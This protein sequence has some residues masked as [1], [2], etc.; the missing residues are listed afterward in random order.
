MRFYPTKIHLT[1]LCLVLFSITLNLGCSKDTDVL[2]DTVAA[3][4]DIS[5]IEEISTTTSEESELEV[6]T[7][8]EELSV[9]ELFESRSVSFSPT[10]DAH[11][12]LGKGY[13]QNIIRLEQNYR[14]SFLMFDLSPIEALGGTITGAILQFTIDSDDGN[15]S[16]S[17]Y[18]GTTNI[19]SEDNLDESTAP[20]MGVELGAIIKEYTIGTTEQIE[21]NSSDISP[22]ISTLILDHEDGNDLAFASKEHISKIGPKLVI[23]YN[24]PAGSEEIFIEE[25][26]EN[27]TEE[28]DTNEEPMAV[29]DASPTSGGAPLEV[30]FTS[31]S[32][33][34]D[35]EVSSYAWDFKDGSTSTE[36]NPVHTFTEVGSYIVELT[37]KDNEG[38]T[39]VDTV[40]ITVG[41]DENLAPKA[42]AS[43]N[44]QTG[45]AP[46]EITFK[47]SDST[48]DYN[49]TSYEWDFKDGSTAAQANPKHTFTTPGVYNVTLTVTDE[50]GLT[51]EG[52]ITITVSENTNEAP[53][54][55]ASVTPA[56]GEAPLQVRF[57]GSNS[58]DDKS[59]TNYAWALNPGGANAAD[60]N[61][62]YA[63]PG[64][65]EVQLVVKDADGLTDSTSLTITVTEPSNEAPVAIATAN[66]TSGE[67]PLNVQFTGTNSTDDKTISSYFWDFK[68]GTTTTSP[69]PD[70]TF[71]EAG[72]YVVDLT[73]KDAEG[74]NSTSSITIKVNEDTSINAPPGYYVSTTGNTSNDGKSPSK[75]WS[76]AHA[77]YKARAGDVVYV[78]AGNYGNVKLDVNNS[79]TSGNPISFIGYKTTPGDINSSNGSTYTFNNYKSKGDN[80]DATKMPLLLGT[81]S[82][83]K[84]SG[85]GIEIRQQN[86]IRIENF[87]IAKH[88]YGIF[89]SG[90][91]NNIFKNIITTD[92]GDFNPQNSWSLGN[93]PAFTNLTGVGIRVVSSNQVEIINSIAIN[94]GARGLALVSSQNSKITNSS[95]YSDNNTNPTDYYIMIYATSNSKIT[96]CHVERVGDLAHYGHGISVKVDAT[97]NQFK[98]CTTKGT[99]FE[100]NNRI[101]HNTFTDCHVQGTGQALSGGWE[102]TNYSHDNTFINCSNDSGEGIVFSD[103]PEDDGNNGINTAAFN[104]TFKNCVITNVV[105][106]SG[107]PINFH[108]NSQAGRL[109]SYARDNTFEGCTFSG[110]EYLFKVDRVNSGNKFINCTISDIEN[111]R[112]SRTSNNTGLQL[113]VSFQNTTTSNIGFTLPN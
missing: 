17:V 28:E 31:S 92:H 84:G 70:H 90:G 55:I 75:P 42:V 103:W 112:G 22:E 79:G 81:R 56:S 73:V 51:D 87:M 57:T 95:V 107:A 68:D 64:T 108:Y 4:S 8:S 54:A 3:D 111:L 76:I 19:W 37:V 78:K 96:N 41:E 110:A 98:N 60:F 83:G 65:Y 82:N 89:N 100:L 25:P 32:S 12:Q 36:M 39:N 53:K 14:T 59:V 88:E 26:Q 48:D 27:N 35:N 86:N 85:M 10:N 30:N 62:T 106:H 101:H 63:N 77:F 97:Y 21:L 7:T 45:E 109:T 49:I 20:E 11:Y 34:D 105:I 66:K 6:E 29:L 44:V 9:D 69:N 58:T 2:L 94:N 40:T 61:Y 72:N 13:N 38:L 74:I 99:S 80:L 50:S 18:K 33:S 113:G 1:F 67:A 102:V 47:G 91:N 43:S 23:S 16:I 104:N 93:A 24:V 71:T 46:I 52:S 5:S 15:G